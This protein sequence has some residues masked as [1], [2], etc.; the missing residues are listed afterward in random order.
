VTG[1]TGPV[2]NEVLARNVLADMAPWGTPADWCE[3]FNPG[4]GPADVSGLRI[5]RSR[6][7]TGAWIIPAG[8]TIP[9]NGYLAFWCDGTRPAD[10]VTNAN[11]NTGFSLGDFS[12]G[13]YLINSSG[14]VVSFI[15]WGAQVIDRSIGRDAGTWKLLSVPTRGAANAVAAT[16]GSVANLKIN[17]WASALATGDWFE[18]Y[19][20][21]ANPVALAGLYLTDDPGEVGRTKFQVAPLSFLGGNASE[22]AWLQLFADGAPLLGKNHVSFQLS[23]DAEYLRVSINDV[24]LTAIDTVS[25][26]LQAASATQGRIVDGQGIQVGLIPTPGAKNLM[27]PIIMS[28]PQPVTVAA[29]SPA[30]FSASVVGSEPLAFQWRKNG[31]N[32]QN[33]TANPLQIGSA[34]ENDDGLYDLVVTN[35]VGD[36]TSQSARL[37]VQLTFDQWR[38]NRFTPGELAD[39]NLSGAGADFD[40]DGI[41]NAQEFF[42]NSNPK[43][44]DNGVGS[45]QVGREPATGQ[46]TFLTLTYRQSA[47]ATGLS[48]QH[49]IS[50]L[51]ENGTW[52][53][54]SPTVTETLSLDPITGDPV[55]RVK[56]PVTPSDTKKFLRLQLTP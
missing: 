10:L 6:D 38:A 23:S 9:A 20:P 55:K 28:H 12:D 34:T 26:G 15:E 53:N 14:Q 42:Q 30:N 44:S 36:V 43:L 47:R 41:T 50:D 51:L 49:Q 48:I 56:F 54:I 37:V 32:V 39:P 16:L 4:A 35:T 8:T 7:G 29:N 13:L 21:D 2:L 17:E 3:L 22:S 24:S 45:I 19:N 52:S 5:G 27:V 46:P 25:F 40:K 1:Y 31:T 11:L 18:L 33:A